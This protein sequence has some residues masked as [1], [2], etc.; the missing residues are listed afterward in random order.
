MSALDNDKNKSHEEMFG[1]KV[2][3]FLELGQLVN[4]SLTFCPLVKFIIK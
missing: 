3:V 4:N 2:E 1:L